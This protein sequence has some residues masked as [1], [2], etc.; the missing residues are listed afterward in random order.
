[1]KADL[2][3]YSKN[4]IG[5]CLLAALPHTSQLEAG[6]DV[7]V[8]GAFLEGELCSEIP[9]GS[10]LGFHS[11]RSDEVGLVHTADFAVASGKNIGIISFIAS[12]C[13][14]MAKAQAEVE[15]SLGHVSG[16]LKAS[17]KGCIEVVAAGDVTGL[18]GAVLL[19]AVML[20]VGHLEGSVWA[21]LPGL[22]I[23][24]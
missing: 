16:E 12:A 19:V 23:R 5:A 21:Y 6:H 9:A 15:A 22:L 20:H 1:M 3:P 4:A 17:L 2:S 8:V 11:Q 13:K 14:G 7:T 18:Q 10:K 24:F